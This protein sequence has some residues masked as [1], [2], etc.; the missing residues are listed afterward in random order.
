VATIDSITE[1]HSP[2]FVKP[3]AIN[4]TLNDEKR[5]W[6]AV[7]SYNSVSIL[8][9]HK[10]RDAFVLVK[11]LRPA[12]LHATKTNGYTY[13][14]CAGIIDKKASDIQIAKEEV[15]EE[16]GYDV[17]LQNIQKVTTFYPSVG[18]TGAYQTLYYAEIDN[19]MHVNEGGGL[20]DENI[21]VIY[22]PT[23]EAKEFM[24]DEN[25]LKT[26]GMMMAFYWFFDKKANI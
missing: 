17:P 13:E 23:Q 26:P 8:L 4:Y 22:L 14:L 7:I 1:L 16:C 12:V 20:A 21:E 18:V 10:E 15:V 11:Q 6:E 19:S 5:V 24:F 9:W 25:F 2:A 3:I